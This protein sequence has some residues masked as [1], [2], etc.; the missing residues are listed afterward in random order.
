MGGS[1]P[2][3]DHSSRNSSGTYWSGIA[4][5][6][7]IHLAVL[8]AVSVAAL[9]YLNW[10]SNAALAEFMAAGKP[11]ATEPSQL[12]ES[13]VPVQQVKNKTPCPGKV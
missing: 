8:F 7:A 5:I 1:M 4:G 10:S 13:S 3:L 11:A 6:L 9:A 12:P 2:S